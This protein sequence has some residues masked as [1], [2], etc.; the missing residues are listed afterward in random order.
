MKHRYLLAL[1]CL[2]WLGAA[3]AQYYPPPGGG[4]MDHRIYTGL[5]WNPAESGWGINTTHQGNTVFA[6]LF[7]YAADGQPLWLV[8]PN[9]VGMGGFSGEYGVQED[10]TFSGPLYRTTGPPF[11]ANPW[12]PIGFAQVG[13]M[14]I[15]WTSELTAVLAYS[16]NGVPVTKSVQRQVFGTPVPECVA[17]SGSRA[18]ETN[19]QDLW[20]NPAESGWGINLV[21]QGTIVFA[22][23]FTYAENGRD[24]WFVAPALAR[25]PD[26]AFA[27]ALFSTTGPAFDAIPW[28][29]IGFAPV[30]DMA[31]RFMDGENATLSYSVN[32]IPVTKAIQRQVFSAVTSACR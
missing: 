9:L 15:T 21:H 10:P 14:T 32:G 12:V 1:A 26:G 19:Y 27:G 31:L 17:V 5:W 3:H 6:T 2:A 30:G 18:G 20:W 11:N 13:T 8:A 25:Q 28:V 29:P 7:T 4:G 23:L 16:V 22:T 24:R